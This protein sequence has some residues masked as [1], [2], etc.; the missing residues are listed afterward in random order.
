MSNTPINTTQKYTPFFRIHLN[1]GS[2]DHCPT[3]S[4]EF[5]ASLVGLPISKEYRYCTRLTDRDVEF[6]RSNQDLKHFGALKAGSCP[7]LKRLQVEMASELE[8]ILEVLERHTGLQELDSKA[9]QVTERLA[10]LHGFPHPI[11]TRR[12]RSTCWRSSP[13]LEH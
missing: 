9:T 13:M 10:K 12:I 4:R 8:G 11:R 7:T 2:R 1:Y 5:F 6:A 3:I